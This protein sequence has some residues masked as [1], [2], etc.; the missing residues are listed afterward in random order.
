[1]MG[2]L[3]RVYKDEKGIFLIAEDMGEVFLKKIKGELL[4]KGYTKDEAVALKKLLGE[5]NDTKQ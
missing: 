5:G 2:T 4:A 3:Y 1:M